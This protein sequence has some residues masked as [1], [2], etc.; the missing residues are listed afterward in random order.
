MSDGNYNRSHLP[1]H[2]YLSG[3]KAGRAQM[4]QI[5]IEAFACWLGEQGRSSQDIETQTTRF[6]ELLMLKETVK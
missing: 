1:Y 6:R 3:L 5:A 4:K 2:P